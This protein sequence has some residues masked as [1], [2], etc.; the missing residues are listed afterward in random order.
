M[1]RVHDKNREVV[2]ALSCAVPLV[3][4]RA[5][6]E[7]DEVRAPHGH[8]FLSLLHC[9]SPAMVAAGVLLGSLAALSQE[10]GLPSSASAVSAA[11]AW[12]WSSWASSATSTQ[13]NS[14]ARFDFGNSSFDISALSRGGSWY[15]VQDGANNVGGLNY[16]YYIN[17]A[18]T[19][20]ASILPG[21][22]AADCNTTYVGSGMGTAGPTLWGPAPA[23]QYSNPSAQPNQFDKCHRLGAPGVAPD[24]T[25]PPAMSWGL[26]DP[27]NPSRGVWVQYDGGDQ[28]RYSMG[29]KARALRIWLLCYDDATNIPDDEVVLESQTCAYDIFLKSAFGCPIQCPIST[30]DSGATRRI[31]AGHGVCDF[32]GARGAPRCFCNGGFYGDDCSQAGAAPAPR[33]TATGAILI[34]VSLVLVATLAFLAWI[35]FF[36]IARL[37]LDPTAYSSLQAGPGADDDAGKSG[38][39]G[40]GGAIN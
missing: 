26:Y 10:R 24:V 5:R 32:D 9:A 7:E 11:P 19:I 35:W 14:L 17:F 37:R 22:A 29:R 33:V 6:A 38:G 4:A 13:S 25:K 8:A 36:K 2:E 40:G 27:A 30:S 12:P 31:C 18:T 3:G 34:G 23:Y 20:D 16:S 15:R 1:Q 21:A 39:A 28:C